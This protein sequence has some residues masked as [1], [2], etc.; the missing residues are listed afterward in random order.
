MAVRKRLPIRGLDP[1][2]KASEAGCTGYIAKPINT[3][4]FLNIIRKFLDHGLKSDLTVYN[5]V[6]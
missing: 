6:P 4:S 3:R 5:H 2:K 1:E